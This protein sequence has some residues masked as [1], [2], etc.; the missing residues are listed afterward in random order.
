ME[1]DMNIFRKTGLAF[2]AAV[3]LVASPALA[4]NVGLIVPV[5]LPGADDIIA[6]LERETYGVIGGSIQ[7]A[8]TYDV[9]WVDV[10]GDAV[11]EDGFKAGT[12][13]IALVGDGA[14]LDLYV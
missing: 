14:D 2:A 1:S 12:T 5:A 10:F 8:G 9:T 6:E 4:C 11:I 7:G 3:L 13:V